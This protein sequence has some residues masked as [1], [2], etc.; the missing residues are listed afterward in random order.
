MLEK[1]YKQTD[2]VKTLITKL[3]N[4][5]NEYS[6]YKDDVKRILRVSRINLVPK[7]FLITPNEAYKGLESLN[8]SFNQNLNLINVDVDVELK[9]SNI[10]SNPNSKF[11]T[12]KIF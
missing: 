11:Y 6:K 8:M 3:Q 10:L 4:S 5:I 7:R 12:F 2:K 1:I 9:N